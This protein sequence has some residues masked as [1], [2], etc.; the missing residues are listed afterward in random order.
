MTH[1]RMCTSI[2]SG[3]R[4]EGAPSLGC[5]VLRFCF[6]RVCGGGENAERQTEY[7]FAECLL[8]GSAKKESTLSLFPAVRWEAQYN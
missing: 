4:S 7:V 1:V 6:R 3:R 2:A 8:Y 5:V